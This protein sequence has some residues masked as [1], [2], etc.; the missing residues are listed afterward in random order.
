MSLLTARCVLQLLHLL[1]LLLLLVCWL[2]GASGAG[3]CHAATAGNQPLQPACVCVGC[4]GRWRPCL[5][6]GRWQGVGC[7]TRALLV[8]QQLLR[9]RLLLWLLLLELHAAGS[10]PLLSCSTQRTRRRGGAG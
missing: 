3:R 10:C 2:P 9:Q 5:R 1:H 7:C 6:L 4:A 8:C